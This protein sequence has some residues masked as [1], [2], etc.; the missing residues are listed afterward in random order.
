MKIESFGV[1]V[2]WIRCEEIKSDSRVYQK[3]IPKRYTRESNA[4]KRIYCPF[5]EGEIQRRKN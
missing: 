1:E 4:R 3:P 5:T 2:M